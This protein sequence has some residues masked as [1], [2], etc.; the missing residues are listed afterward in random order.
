MQ[1][2]RR[3]PPPVHAAR[4]AEDTGVSE[5]TIYR[6]IATLRGAGARIDGEAGYGYTLEEDPALP[7]QTFDRLEL[8]AILLGI[9]NV[10]AAGD[11]ALAEAAD[12]AMSKLI[13]RLPERQRRQALTAVLSIYRWHTP[14]VPSDILAPLREASWDEVALDIEY[15]DSAG[16]GTRRRILPLQIVFLEGT[17]VVLAW[18]CLRQDFRKFRLDRIG[19]LVRS[20][21]SFRPRRVPLLRDY[22]A[23]LGAA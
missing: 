2:L 10:R 6:D 7:P 9:G 13:A 12:S 18:C 3:I 14:E 16:E 1:L 4:L 21:E 17:L 23:R 11:P 20:D 22:L 15:R 5:R 8:E 19:K